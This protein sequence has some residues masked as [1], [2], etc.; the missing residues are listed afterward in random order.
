MYRGDL[1][2]DTCSNPRRLNSSEKGNH[3]MTMTIVYSINKDFSR[4]I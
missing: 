2:E 3:I 4:S 1:L